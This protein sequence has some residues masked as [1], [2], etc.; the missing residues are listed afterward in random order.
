MFVSRIV[1]TRTAPDNLTRETWEFCLFDTPTELHLV[2][3]R[4]F[5]ETRTSTQQRK[6]NMPEYYQRVHNR[7]S[8][9]LAHD[10]VPLPE[11]VC[12]EAKQKLFDC[13]SVTHW[14]GRQ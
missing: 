10:Q 1:V 6:W 13:I 14:K 11:D 9:N 2:P 7:D 3:D 8:S 5:K 12:A 4:Y